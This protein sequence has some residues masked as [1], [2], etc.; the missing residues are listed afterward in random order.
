MT[1]LTTPTVAVLV[2]QVPLSGLNLSPTPNATITD[3]APGYKVGAFV[4]GTLD[5]FAAA[6]PGPGTC[7]YTLSGAPPVAEGLNSITARVFIVD[8]SDDPTVGGTAHVV[9]QGGQ[10][11]ALLISVD[12]VAPAPPSAPDLL[13]TSDSGASNTDNIT[14][15]N[16]PAF[17]GTGE[18]NTR[19]RV[20]ANGVVVGEGVVG[21]DATDGVTGNGLGAWEVTVEPLADGTYTITAVVEDLAGNISAPSAVMAGRPL[22]IDTGSGAPQRPTM[23]LLSEDDTGRSDQDNITNKT[24]LRFRVSADIGTTVVIK[25]GNTVIDTYVQ[26]AA[27]EERAL[28]LAEGPHPLSAESTD[29][30]GNRSGQSEELLVVVDTTKPVALSVPDLLA[31]PGS[32]GIDDDNITT[33]QQPHF[34]GAGEPNALVRLYAGPQVGN[35]VLT[36][37]GAYE[38]SS[39]TLADAVYQV[40][41]TFE[42]LAGNVSLPSPALK[43]TV[44]HDSLTLPGAT[45]SSPAAGPSPWTW[46]P[47]RWPAIPA[48]PV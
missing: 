4:N 28:N 25:D 37:S 8:P 36:S 27:F 12:T 7:V 23:D 39:S 16:A 38:V 26:A 48:S 6:G 29:A 35:S 22:A 46:G 19:V 17:Q 30:A 10:S 13:P 44:A 41:V 15:V 21:S 9:G 20:L 34:A 32:G 5:G 14:N 2:D 11:A 42:D 1:N 3:D 33:H 18:A 31:S 24:T 47:A 40:T 43:V 45:A